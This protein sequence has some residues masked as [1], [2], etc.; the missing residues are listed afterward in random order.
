MKSYLESTIRW[1]LLPISI[2]VQVFVY[3]IYTF[4]CIYFYI[5]KYYITESLQTSPAG[6]LVSL[7]SKWQLD[8]IRDS[9]F[10]ADND[11]HTALT[12]SFLWA[13]DRD[14]AK[15]GL[16]ALVTEEGSLHRRFP[17]ESTERVSGDCL[18][19]WVFAYTISGVHI[20]GLVQK[21]A[22]HYLSQCFGLK[23]VFGWVSAK[24]LNCGFNYV[25]DGS[26]NLNQPVFGPQYFTSA[27]LFG[28]AAKESS[29]IQKLF[30]ETVFLFNFL[31]FG[32][33]LYNFL[34][35][36]HPQS[37][38][39]YY[40]QHIT[41]LNAY[42]LSKARPLRFIY[43]NTL[44]RLLELTNP[45]INPLFYAL[46]LDA[47]ATADLNTW[48]KAKD[49]LLSFKGGYGFM[50]Q[51]VPQPGMIYQSEDDHFFAPLSFVAKLLFIH[52]PIIK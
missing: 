38:R 16:T 52:K 46:Y 14:K 48:N 49:L 2:A 17:V 32:G 6:D 40:A 12:H 50:Y 51:R 44:K 42:S 29:G 22:K 47:G 20:P 28:L 10:S 37:S 33:W 41:V 34:P 15:Q 5:K 36:W 1:A 35:F 27:A 25:H 23:T 3:L 9:C 45:N 4:L 18:S 21:V 26:K 8:P 31:V 19:T 43:R 24:S 39:I 30:W 13:F 7:I 11:D